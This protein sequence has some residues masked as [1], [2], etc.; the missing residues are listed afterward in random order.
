MSGTPIRFLLNG[1]PHSVTALNPH[2]TL[3][4]YLRYTLG[5]T[6]TKE[7][8]AEGDC[9][10]CTVVLGELKGG[11][12][13]YRAVNACILLV[14]TLHG[15]EVIT[16][17]GVQRS[18]GGLHACQQAL[19]DHHGSQ[20]GFCT[21]GFVMSL[22]AH[23]RSN[24]PTDTAS[25]EDALA[26]NL[27]RCTGYGPILAAAQA[28]ALYQHGD[29][30]ADKESERIALLEAL[31]DGEMV[32]L[33]HFNP[34]SQ[35]GSQFFAPKTL[36]ELRRLAKLHPDATY[37]AGAT[38]IGLWITKE[39]REMDVI[40]YLGRVDALSHITE[41]DK[42]LSLGAFV[43]YAQALP[44]LSRTF[45]DLGELVRRIGSPPIRNAGTLGGNIANGSPIGD[46]MPALIALGA[47]LVM[48]GPEGERRLPLEDYFIDYD[49]QDRL[50]GEFVK[51]V[52]IPW[53]AP[54]SVFSSYK[55]SK[56]F[57]QD[58]SAVCAAFAFDMDGDMIASAR[59]AFG[60]MAATPKR[61]SAAEAALE[62]AP[63]TADILAKAKAALEQDFAP[64]TDMRAS[65][66]YR[67]LAAQNLLEKAFLEM[68]HGDIETRLVGP[69]SVSGT[70]VG[71]QHD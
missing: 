17:E 61:A 41:S 28:T 36:E 18:D 59:I 10:A 2:T 67:L 19:V 13:H 48:D 57:D 5:M 45:D 4:P 51:A 30:L 62:G 69:G 29:A 26:G 7:G 42:G 22:Y 33:S 27:C 12:I 55:L 6:G 9:G 3:L 15:K 53:I 54:T 44:I 32:S 16:V 52:D 63:L 1:E 40:I 37:L 39:Q 66:D 35:R 14:A 43:T 38:D 70:A 60:G 47:I 49:K 58:I 46:T 68:T 71:A 11:V 20:C 64:I 56:R 24:S 50:A 31:Q 23:H 65:A 34:I 25:L 21:P 8:C